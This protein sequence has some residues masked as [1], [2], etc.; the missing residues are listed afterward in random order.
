MPIQRTL[1]RACMAAGIVVALSACLRAV[2]TPEAWPCQSSDDCKSNE[3]CVVSA[4]EAAPSPGTCRP[5]GEADPGDCARGGGGCANAPQA[6]AGA[7][8]EEV[9][10]TGG[11]G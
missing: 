6:S 9:G 5:K 1:S 2:S 3:D 8:G 11:T 10:D 7:G 4:A